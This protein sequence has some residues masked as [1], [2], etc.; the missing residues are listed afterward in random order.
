MNRKKHKKSISV[1]KCPR[2]QGLSYVPLEQAHILNTH[3]AIAGHKIASSMPNSNSPGRGNR[4]RATRV[5][6]I[7]SNKA[8]GLH[9]CPWLHAY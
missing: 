1:I 5:M 7:P 6:L 9:S 3:F 2:T 8:H 4:T